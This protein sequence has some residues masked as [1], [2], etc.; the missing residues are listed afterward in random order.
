MHCHINAT[1]HDHN[2]H[3]LFLHFTHSIITIT[4]KK[5]KVHQKKSTSS[6]FPFFCNVA[7]RT[8]DMMMIMRLIYFFH[9]ARYFYSYLLYLYVHITSHK[10]HVVVIHFI[11][12]REYFF[13]IK[14]FLIYVL[15]CAT[16]DKGGRSYL[17]SMSIDNISMYSI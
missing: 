3:L 14:R 8:L 4:T 13:L 10:N 2:L 15:F 17:T 6:S 11:I 1:H 5:P 9:L 16:W 7:S 12:Y